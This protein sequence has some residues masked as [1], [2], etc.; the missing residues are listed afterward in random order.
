MDMD[1][2]LGCVLAGMGVAKVESMTE[3]SWDVT[4]YKVINDVMNLGY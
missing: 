3:V 2:E 4:S 1:F